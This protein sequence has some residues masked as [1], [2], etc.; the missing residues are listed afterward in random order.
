MLG[1]LVEAIERSGGGPEYRAAFVE[2]SLK[3]GH[4][5]QRAGA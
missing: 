1:T 4:V 2:V 5:D 3:T